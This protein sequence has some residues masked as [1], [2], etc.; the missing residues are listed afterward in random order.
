MGDAYKVE[1]RDGNE[2][3]KKQYKVKLEKNNKKMTVKVN[4]NG[5]FM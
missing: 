5:E 2:V 1:Y 3:A 4:E